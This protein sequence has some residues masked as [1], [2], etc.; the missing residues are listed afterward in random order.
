MTKIEKQRVVPSSKSMVIKAS[1]KKHNALVTVV[2]GDA[3]FNVN[4]K[5]MKV[6]LSHQQ[7]YGRNF[8]AFN[9]NTL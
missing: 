9:L 8:I 1:D 7:L 5:S 4:Y 3:T 2:F 6:F